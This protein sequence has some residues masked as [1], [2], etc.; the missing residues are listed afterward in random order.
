MS[1]HGKSQGKYYLNGTCVQYAV[2]PSLTEDQ[3]ADRTAKA[4]ETRERRKAEGLTDRTFKIKF[5]Q[6]MKIFDGITYQHFHASLNSSLYHCFLTATFDSGR[7]PDNPNAV[8]SA[9]LDKLKKAGYRNYVWTRELTKI[10]TPHYHFTVVGPRR[11]INAKTGW[12]INKCWADSR[13]YYSG[14]AVRSSINPV[15]G[16]SQMVVNSLI[17]ARQ[18]VA[19]YIA[20]SNDTTE[21]PFPGRVYS[22]S[23]D[24]NFDALPVK[25]AVG[26]A[27]HPFY[28]D[29]RD[30]IKKDYSTIGGVRPEFSMDVYKKV[31][32]EIENNRKIEALKVKKRVKTSHYSAKSQSVLF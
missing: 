1:D 28:S 26:L 15:S 30:L 24:L 19:K 31:L 7:V 14:N 32:N 20:K 29:G 4:I 27:I 6:R 9:F 12:C 5:K 8:F 13:G 17:H 3:I 2:P 18:Y 25:D 16:K 21:D 11:P 10:G 23:H 22:V